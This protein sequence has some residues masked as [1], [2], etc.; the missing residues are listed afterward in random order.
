MNPLAQSGGSRRS[1][2]S[3]MR[4]VLITLMPYLVSL[5]MVIIATGIAYLAS[6][7]VAS[8]SLS[9]IYLT[10]VL[11][12]ALRYGRWPSLLTSL[13]SVTAWD[14]LFIPPI[15]HFEV[16][17]AEDLLALVLFSIV[18]V[19]VSDLVGRILQQTETIGAQANTT[20]A[21]LTFYHNITDVGSESELNSTVVH[22]IGSM[23]GCEVLL[24]LARGEG[25][26]VERCHPSGGRLRPDEVE[27][28]EIAWIGKRATGLGTHIMPKMP[29]LFLPLY[30]QRSTLGVLAVSQPGGSDFSRDE[31][32]LLTGL[33][34]QTS[35]AIE[36][37]RLA[38]E[39][40]RV[41]AQTETERLRN[42]LLTSVSHD[43]RTPLSTI[44]G[45]HSILKDLGDDCDPK[46]RLELISTAQEEAERLD[47]FVGNLLDMTR[48]EAG[49][50]NVKL[51]PIDLA[52][53]VDATLER[54]RALT[55]TH[56][57]D[58]ALAPDLPMIMADFLLL[59][60]ALFNLV[61]NALKYTPVRSTIRIAGSV[62]G[63]FVLIAVV[64][65]GLGI[66]PYALES[67]FDK[68]ARLKAGDGV[69]AG[70]GLGLP[71]CRGFVEAMGGSISAANRPDRPGAV[72]AIRLAQAVLTLEFAAGRHK[73]VSG[74]PD[75]ICGLLSPEAP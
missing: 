71:I 9:A 48:L 7:V 6:N 8:A 68:F 26:E 39:V 30:T 22:Q 14:Y 19:I 36:R 4:S 54:M 33:A 13:L 11:F 38:N 42:A 61:D 59:E 47:R 41:Q 35:A 31:R 46:T 44:L 15:Y 16:A 56:T 62:D 20:A 43:L 45:A 69:K 10:A 28:A 21:L 2:A 72:F 12:S 64:D 29:H 53:V 18:A 49:G 5:G 25:L 23:L 3:F 74:S 65:E 67:V 57:I 27:A 60:Q 70:T 34:D 73:I 75:R 66:P 58:V 40:H 63:D 55:V 51:E 24:L 50:V 1:N 52:E 17:N 32:G 37:L